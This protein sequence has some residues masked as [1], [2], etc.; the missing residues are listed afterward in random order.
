MGK[1]VLEQYIEYN[2]FGTWLGM[3]FKEIQVG[4]IE[5]YLTIE[6]QH[7]ATPKSV[8]GGVISALVDAT[9][10]VSGLSAVHKEGK[11]VSTIEYKLNFMSPVAVG[12]L[13]VA[14]GKVEQ[15]GKS[16]LV[17]S[18]E[19]LSKNTGKIVAKALGT[20]NSYDASKAGYS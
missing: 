7:L 15:K 1:S 3:E 8:H 17:I 11:V 20:F 19:V 9:L 12:E 13:L 14:Y 5:Y 6:K 4:E 2:Q 16:I 10:G 18:C